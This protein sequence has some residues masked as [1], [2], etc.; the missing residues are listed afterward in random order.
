M[1]TA[2][3]IKTANSYIEQLDAVFSEASKPCEYLI[4]AHND[5]RI[6]Q[7]LARVLPGESAAVLEVP[8]DTWEHQWRQL[9]ETIEWA[10]QQG[11]IKHVVLVGHSQPG[12]PASRAA[13][14]TAETGGQSTR[15]SSY[16]CLLD[17]V[18]QA[19]ARNQDAQQRFAS[20]VQAMSQIPVVHNRWVNDELAVHGLFY[21]VESR[22][23]LAYDPDEDRFR[24]LIAA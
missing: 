11:K 2:Y 17:R 23:F 16:D 9:S 6:L 22:L 5:S 12:G 15:Q 20:H 3:A 13:L 4:I 19:N 1:T 24:P 8:Q 10:L 14:L 18:R 7:S 21:R